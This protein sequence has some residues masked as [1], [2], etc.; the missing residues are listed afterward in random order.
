MWGLIQR[1]LGA[2]RRSQQLVSPLLRVAL[3]LGVALHLAGFLLFRILSS[4][5]PERRAA[6][7]FVQYVSADSLANA[8]ELDEQAA[9]FD[10]APLFIPTRWNASQA[11]SVDL[12]DVARGQLAEFEP[13]I[14]LLA[15]LQPAEFGAAAD[16]E[17]RAPIDLLAS[18][19]WRFF[20]GFPQV[21]GAPSALPAAQPVAQVAVVGA[22]LAA[23][24]SLAA[25]LTYTTAVPI[26]GPV[27]YY[28]RVSA[29]GLP[30]GAPMLGRSSGND[31]FDAAAAAWLGRAEVR[32]QLPS[33]Y[34]AITVFPW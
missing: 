29:A 32:A 24:Q 18:R 16:L 14:D 28:Q 23:V 27:L 11:S 5:L 7:A 1:Y 19:Y 20:D 31:A 12:T 26:D 6:P 15:E 4:P 3:L 33:G 13:Q 30:L 9:L 34:V 22:P 17:V 21:P 2:A 25:S 8:S 10:S